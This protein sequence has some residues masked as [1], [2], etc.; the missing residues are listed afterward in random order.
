M[1]VLLVYIDLF[2]PFTGYTKH[3][4]RHPWLCHQAP[5]L[6]ML[7]SI[8]MCQEK[9]SYYTRWIFHRLDKFHVWLYFYYSIN[10]VL[11]SQED[12]FYVIQYYY[13]NIYILLWITSTQIIAHHSI[14]FLWFEIPLKQQTVSME[15]ILSLHYQWYIW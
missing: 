2:I 14:N 10:T 9:F 15:K 12:C 11:E 7:M 1:S 8:A 13:S 5:T 4:Q 3:L 6:Y